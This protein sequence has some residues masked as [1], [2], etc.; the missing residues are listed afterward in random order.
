VL[1]S[2]IH[3]TLGPHQCH[4]PR[5]SSV[6]PRIRILCGQCALALCSTISPKFPLNS[7][8]LGP[9]NPRAYFVSAPHSAELSSRPA[10]RSNWGQGWRC[11]PA[12]SSDAA[13]MLLCRRVQRGS[14]RCLVVEPILPPPLDA[15]AALCRACACVLSPD[16]VP[17]HHVF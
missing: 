12:H 2:S 15:A 14:S 5:L 10:P 13:V 17:L 6:T 8:R 16:D 4:T 7:H 3:S 9:R 1:H 11:A